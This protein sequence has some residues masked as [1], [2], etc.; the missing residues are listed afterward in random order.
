VPTLLE[1]QRAMRSSLVDRDDDAAAAM[2][3]EHVGADRLDIYRN[4]FVAGVTKALRLIYPAVHRLVGAAFFE[5]AA[6]VFIAQHPPRA[7]W[8]DEYGAEF[9]EFL[10]TFRP[11]ATLAYLA[12]VARLERAVNRAIHAPD[13]APLALERL[14]EVAPEHQM[15]VRFVPHPSIGLLRTAHPADDIWRG[16]LNAD[17]AA[18]AAVDP[19][20]G[21][22]HLLVERGDAGV[23]VSRLDEPAWRFVAALCGGRTVDAACAGVSGTRACALLA[24]Q[25]AAGRFVDFRVAPSA[26][27]MPAFEAAR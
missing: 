16:V 27:P 4:T 18:L 19:D 11:A 23:D 25:L 8:L 5:G 2:L 14:A 1:L 20:G 17:D 9:P 15:L 12:D 10:Q 22:V 7:A 21:P 3:A 24:E 6:A 26:A 13:I